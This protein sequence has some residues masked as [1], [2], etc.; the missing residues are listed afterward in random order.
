MRALHAVRSG[1]WAASLHALLVVA[2]LAGCAHEA[3]QTS[4]PVAASNEP[5]PPPAVAQ[6]QIPPAAPT[7]PPSPVVSGVVVAVAPTT[8]PPPNTEAFVDQP[9]MRD[10]F[11][12]PGRAHIGRQGA[13]AMKSNVRWLLDNPDYVLLVEGHTDF[14]GTR[15]S[16]LVIAQQRAT[17]AVSV[18]R[19]SGIPT[20]RLHTVSYGSDRP[21]CREK[22]DACA[23]K[24]RRVHFR[25]KRQ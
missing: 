11:F 6:P 12:E 19:E 15:E 25:V 18:L 4:A 24:N 16:N 8:V 21:V 1:L 2:T 7:W 10:V 17:S 9:A 23:A 5:A 3:S 14:S 22:S 13:A 20:A